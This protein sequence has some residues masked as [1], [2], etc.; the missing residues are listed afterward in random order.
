MSYLLCC[1]WGTSNFRLYLLD[2]STQKILGQLEDSNGVANIYSQWQANQE[3]DKVVY[4]RVFL[5]DKI[6]Q[7][8]RQY[9]INLFDTPIVLSGM[10]GS[11]IG[12]KAVPYREVPLNIFQP[13]LNV[14]RIKGTEG[15]SNDLFLFGGLTTEADV[16]RG[17]EVQLIGLSALLPK[18]DCLC[19]LPGTH[20]K[21]IYIQKGHLISFSTFMTGELFHLIKAHSILKNS[22]PSLSSVNEQNEYFKQGVEEGSH[23]DFLRHLFRIRVN[24]LLYDI[25]IEHNQDY[26]SGLLIGAELRSVLDYQGMIVLTAGPALFKHY[27]K[28]MEILKQTTSCLFIPPGKLDS[29][30]PKAHYI[31]MKN[32][33]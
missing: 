31:L 28:A 15:F 5:Q 30:I 13:Q 33:K 12:I 6:L 19:I 22:L 26:L 14:Y 29:A 27:Q 25:P 17:E 23:D 4:Y 21:H 10:A 24:D 1:D 7:L 8:E 32:I 2:R 16:M 3:Q 18:E 20:S 11:S 9:S